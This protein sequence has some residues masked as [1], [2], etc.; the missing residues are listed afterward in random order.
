VISKF[1]FLVLIV[2]L[3]VAVVSGVGRSSSV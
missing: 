1:L 3:I 2:A